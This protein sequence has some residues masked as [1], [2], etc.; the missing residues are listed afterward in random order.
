VGG[1]AE[2]EPSRSDLLILV[3]EAAI[4]WTHHGV[5]DHGRIN[6]TLKEAG[7]QVHTGA[8]CD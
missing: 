2:A 3:L 5:R 8:A 1:G 4:P 6:D 7:D